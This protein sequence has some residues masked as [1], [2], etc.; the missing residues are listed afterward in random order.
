MAAKD[1]LDRNS[2]MKRQAILKRRTWS[3]YVFFCQQCMIIKTMYPF[4]HQKV[5]SENH[6]GVT[7]IKMGLNRRHYVMLWR[8][9]LLFD[10]M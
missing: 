9:F 8:F 6:A 10:N 2:L 7:G 4:Y 5:S 1:S 3:T